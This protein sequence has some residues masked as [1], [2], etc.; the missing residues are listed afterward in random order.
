MGR[1]YRYTLIDPDH[2]EVR[3]AGPDG[4]FDTADDII[5]P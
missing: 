4:I 3:S 2:N 1:V 5:N